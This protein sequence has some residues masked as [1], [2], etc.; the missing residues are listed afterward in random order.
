MPSNITL[1]CRSVERVQCFSRRRRADIWLK[2]GQWL[3]FTCPSTNT[4]SQ[5]CYQLY[6]NKVSVIK[7]TETTFKSL[8]NDFCCSADLRLLGKPSLIKIDVS[9]MRSLLKQI[10]F[11]R[12]FSK[13]KSLLVWC[14][15]CSWFMEQTRPL[16]DF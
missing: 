2:R 10:F 7:H 1:R 4:M 12:F 11:S 6:S 3:S 16:W 13:L 9:F 14:L 8:C 5:V 15:M